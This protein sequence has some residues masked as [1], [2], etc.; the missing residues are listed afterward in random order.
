[1]LISQGHCK[2]S[3]HGHAPHAG[4][5]DLYTNRSC[6]HRVLQVCQALFG[7]LYSLLMPSL[8][9]SEDTWIKECGSEPA[10]LPL[11]CT[12]RPQLSRQWNPKERQWF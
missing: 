2:Q 5:V 8:Q 7:A 10:D 1:M 6:P 12:I 4:A 11:T 9:R 3:V